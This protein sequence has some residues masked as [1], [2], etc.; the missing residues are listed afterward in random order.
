MLANEDISRKIK[1]YA[2][3]LGFDACGIC[4]AEP[5]EVEEQQH[6]KDWINHSYHA[7][8]DYM[9]RNTEKRCNPTLLVE[10]SRSVISVA[11]NY[12]PEA[13]QPQENTQFAYYAY[14]KDYHDVV[15]NKLQML[16]D[17][18]KSLEPTTEGR[19]FVDTAPT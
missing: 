3:S 2:Y 10:G 18:I 13:K 6:F 7:D 15:K 12:Y 14:G 19:A 17:Y 4:K 11:L 9:A 1:D 8:M 5:I 16:L